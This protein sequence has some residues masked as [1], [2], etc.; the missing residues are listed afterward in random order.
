MEWALSVFG[1]FSGL[2]TE[3]HTSL[4][5]GIHIHMDSSFPITSQDT[6]L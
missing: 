6:I 4:T 2:D 5:D 3:E 1:L